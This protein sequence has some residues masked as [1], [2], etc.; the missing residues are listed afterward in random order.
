[1][2]TKRDAK[3]LI[4]NHFIAQH[5]IDKSHDYVV[6]VTNRLK[7]LDLIESLKN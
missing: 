5:Y 4:P 6:E 2:E 3:G 1:M 7:W